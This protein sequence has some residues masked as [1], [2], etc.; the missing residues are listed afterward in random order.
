MS[1]LKE[2]TTQG[3]IIKNLGMLT[4]YYVCILLLLLLTVSKENC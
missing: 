2:F 4:I 3:S 1:Q